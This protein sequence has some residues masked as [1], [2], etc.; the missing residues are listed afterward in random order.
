ML[1]RKS[2]LETRWRFLAG[3]A[4]LMVVACGTPLDYRATQQL[5]P[6][7]SAIDTSGP[8]GQ[9]IKAVVDLERDYRGFVWWQWFRQ[10]L[11]QIWTTFAVLLGSGGLIVNPS[12]GAPLFM[13]SMPVSRG[14]VAWIRAATVLAELL[15]LAIV[16]SLV[17]PILSPAFGQRYSAG[18]ALVHGGCVFVAGAMFFSLAFLLSTSFADLWRPLLIASAVALALA[19]AEQAVSGGV[20]VGVFRVMSGETYFRSGHLPWLGLLFS[21]ATAAALLYAASRNIA[22]RDF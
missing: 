6:L 13:L 2:W 20:P 14:R 8:F 18:A 3:L 16:P 17:I 4:L 21:V 10:N 15:V 22:R 12:G 19:L 1:W 7:A 5:L 9:R 11:S